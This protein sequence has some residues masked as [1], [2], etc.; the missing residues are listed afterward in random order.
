VTNVT[1]RLI[2]SFCYDSQ[3]THAI[4]SSGTFSFFAG[5]LQ[6]PGGLVLYD[7]TGFRWDKCV[8]LSHDGNQALRG[9]YPSEWIDVFHHN[10]SQASVAKPSPIVLH[11]TKAIV[12]HPRD[13]RWAEHKMHKL[14]MKGSW[15][16]GL[17]LRLDDGS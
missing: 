8:A 2:S 11:E 4:I 7:R 16:D 12:A 3:C 5:F 9:Y 13:V 10:E 15:L 1:P 6:Q 17:T 14:T